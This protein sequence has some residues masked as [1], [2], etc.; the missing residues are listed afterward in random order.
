MT[1]PTVQ[2]KGTISNLQKNEP[3]KRLIHSNFL[4]TINTQQRYAQDDPHLN[5]DAEFFENTIQEMLN[6][7]EHYI[8]LPEGDSWNNDTIKNVDI[9][10]TVER[11]TKHGQLHCHILLKFD[12]STKVQLDYAKIREKILKDT[13]LKNIYMYNRLVRNSGS[14][15]ILQYLD[16][17]N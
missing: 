9:D 17:F 11:G 5:D 10:Y 13:G 2:V 12:H 1:K 3:K 15:N 16:K 14:Q 6:S 4:L 8:K 7:V